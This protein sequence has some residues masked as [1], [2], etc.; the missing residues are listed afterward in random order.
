[1]TTAT[2]A[3]IGI[4]LGSGIVPR[5]RPVLVLLGAA[6]AVIADLDLLAPY[7]GGDRDFHRRFTH[8]I[9]FALLVGLSCAAGDRLA[10]HSRADS[11]RVG[12][13]G[14][15]ATLSHGIAD[16]LTTYPPGV[17]LLS[18]FSQERYHLPWRPITNVTREVAFVFL[19]AMFLAAGL[20]RFRKRVSEARLA[21]R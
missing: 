3:V 11:V 17:A 15:L 2:H 5:Q 13:Y 1:M 21:P 18:P 10:R 6:C 8:S 4:A 19:P 12:C 9:P 20:L 7:V 16:M 14:A